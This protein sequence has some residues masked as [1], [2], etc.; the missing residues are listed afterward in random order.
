MPHLA[1]VHFVKHGLNSTLKMERSIGTP[2]KVMKSLIK[3]FS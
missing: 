3:H 2:S 1:V